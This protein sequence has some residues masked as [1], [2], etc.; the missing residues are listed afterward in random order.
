M[1]VALQLVSGAGVIGAFESGQSGA[2]KAAASAPATRDIE[3]QQQGMARL[4]SFQE[5]AADPRMRAV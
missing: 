4:K 5:S 1:S 3:Y 2:L